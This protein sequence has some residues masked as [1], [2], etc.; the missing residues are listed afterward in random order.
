MTDYPTRRPPA[1]ERS[2]TSQAVEA[3]IVEVAARIA[4]PELA[5]MFANA[6][7]NTLD[8]TITFA[9][10]AAGRP[11]T[12]VI[13]G[14]IDAMWLRDSTN[15]VWP[16]LSLLGSDDALDRLIQ[17]VIHRQVRC[18]TLDRFANAFYRDDK[19]GH[20]AGDHTDM[21]P[22][23]HERKYELDSLAAVLR[24]STGYFEASGCE[25]PFDAKWL[26]AMRIIVRTIDEQRAGSDEEPE[27]AYQFQ[28]AA[29]S[30][31][32]TLPL[33]G[34]G[35]P[36]RRC[37]LS[38]SPFRPSDDA[39][40][41]PFLVP[42]NAM[43]TVALTRLNDLLGKLGLAPDLAGEAAALADELRGAI[44]RHA[45][46][47]H[48]STARSC[49]PDRWVRFALPDGRRK[50]TAAAQSAT[51]SGSAMRPPRAT[52]A[53]ERSGSAKRTCISPA[54]R[55]A[56]GSVDPHRDGLDLAD[57]DHERAHE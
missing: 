36:A 49:L 15:Q 34:R 9:E 28:R 46:V 45:V 24:L 10:D 32:D 30:A 43:A 6:L 19:V 56:R 57:G 13:T 42:A 52:A 3:A 11:D 54:A 18:V 7:P 35:H 48:R 53:R 47:D 50:Y 25:E 44:D 14:D 16:Y 33:A 1:A 26:A 17:G 39:A 20:W 23:V 41:L 27:P 21:R 8:T 37:G 31:L 5:W 4:D 55:R 51:T 22:G 12:F 2:F 40:S 29:K 38:K